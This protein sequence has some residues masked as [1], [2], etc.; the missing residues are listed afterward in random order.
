V[1]IGTSIGIAMAR[2]VPFAAS[3]FVGRADAML[4]AAKQAGRGTY[5]LATIGSADS[6]ANDE[7]RRV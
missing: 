4:Y 1:S 5:R 3:E 7:R 2:A 6:A